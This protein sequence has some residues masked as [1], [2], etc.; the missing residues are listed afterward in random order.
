VSCDDGDPCTADAC[1]EGVG[2]QHEAIPD[3]DGDGLC[4]AIDDSDGDGVVDLHDDCPDTAP[5]AVADATGCACADAGHRSCDDGDVCTDDACD[6]ATAR[7]THVARTC[8]DDD[9][10]T[11][12]VCDPVAGCLHAPI[13]D[14]DA[15]G[16]CDAVDR[17]PLLPGAPQDDADGDG[18]GD[19][20]SCTAPRP[21]ACIPAAGKAF[22]RCLVEWRVDA[23]VGV[24]RGLPV[25]RV[26]CRD[27]DPACDADD[28]GGQCTFRAQ[29]C[30]N[31]A[32]PRFPACVPLATHR[33]TLAGR[34]GT[35]ARRAADAE[36]AAA[37]AG[38][39]DL[40]AQTPNQCGAPV[41]LVVPT[42]GTRPGKRVVALRAET[43]TGRATATLRL[44]CLP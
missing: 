18:V 44:S 7:C 8:A 32:D 20:C 33:L 38:A 14:A 15:D 3:G 24:R 13:G 34:K 4:D 40:R 23:R 27:G 16:L 21:G 19:A 31:N 29:A 25:G 12:D 42:R 1:R 2:C 5:G 28:V 35:R 37:L 11:A 36:L 9:P 26:A 6:P 22:Q 39:L 30:I 41:A 17:C 43:K 10:C